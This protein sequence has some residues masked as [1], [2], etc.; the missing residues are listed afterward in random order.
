MKV[1]IICGITLVILGAA[2]LGYG[3]ISYTTQE[4]VL[5][6]GPIKATE[7]RTKSIPIP[8]ILGWSL[9]ASGAGVL[10]LGAT[11]KNW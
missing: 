2:A 6:I 10:I 1:L 4:K 5:D 7:D 3:N 11:R 9:L 8:P